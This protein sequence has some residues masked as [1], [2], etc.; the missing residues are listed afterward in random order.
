MRR[1]HWFVWQYEKNRSIMIR[2]WTK[3]DSKKSLILFTGAV[4]WWLE[5]GNE[6]RNL[7]LRFFVSK[8]WLHS[9][10]KN[11]SSSSKEVPAIL[12]NSMHI[13]QSTCILVLILR[14]STVIFIICIGKL[15]IL[16]STLSILNGSDF[17]RHWQ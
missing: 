6:S 2:T 1:V 4:Q 3:K 12:K 11:K 13:A 15:E 16:L 14:I 8:K 5:L 17:C 9:K 10:K 7:Y